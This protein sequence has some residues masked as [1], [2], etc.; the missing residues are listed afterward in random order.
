MHGVRC[1]TDVWTSVSVTP[2]VRQEEMEFDV[3]SRDG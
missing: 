2:G 1:D 3:L